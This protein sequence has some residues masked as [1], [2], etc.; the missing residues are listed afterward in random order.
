MSEWQESR[1]PA[2]WAGGSR[3]GT[4]SFNS[5]V[6]RH[7][8]RSVTITVTY[9]TS[10]SS[11]GAVLELA[12]VLTQELVSVPGR[13]LLGCPRPCPHLSS[14]VPTCGAGFSQTEGA[15]EPGALFLLPWRRSGVTGWGQ[16]WRREE[17]APQWGML[18]KGA[19]S[20]SWDSPRYL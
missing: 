4:S 12:V 2:P 1:S 16:A 17:T 3:T 20:V 18:S 8:I 14:S 7:R 19:R 15:I 6:F 11:P 13:P 5:V 9:F 10:T